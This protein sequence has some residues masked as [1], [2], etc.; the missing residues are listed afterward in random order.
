MVHLDS[1]FTTN[2]PESVAETLGIRYHHMDVA[3]IVLLFVG[4]IGVGA[5]VPGTVVC[6]C[7][8]VSIVVLSLRS[9]EGL[10]GMLAPD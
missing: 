5:I 7:V 4:I 2:V 9:A 6:L 10:Y 3:V 1:Y 8:A